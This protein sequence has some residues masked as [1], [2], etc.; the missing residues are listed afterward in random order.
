MRHKTRAYATTLRHELDS[1]GAGGEPMPSLTSIQFLEH[2]GA[3]NLIAT[4]RN[5]E[6]SYW[7]VVNVVELSRLL[8]WAVETTRE[9]GLRPGQIVI[10][11]PL[12][13]WKWDPQPP[14]LADIDE[15][16]LVSVAKLAAGVAEM[17]KTANG[18]SR[19]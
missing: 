6:L 18:R 14:G 5:L 15:Q 1:A 13:D 8:H 7:W 11:A 17:D 12:A 9:S 2:L 3:I 19:I 16:S 10:I 4:F